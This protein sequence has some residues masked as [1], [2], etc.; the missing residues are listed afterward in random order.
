MSEPR[1]S[2]GEMLEPPPGVE[3]TTSPVCGRPIP[4]AADEDRCACQPCGYLTDRGKTGR[5]PSMAWD[6]GLCLACVHGCCE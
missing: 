1:W 4:V 6:G 5:C 2:N 3:M